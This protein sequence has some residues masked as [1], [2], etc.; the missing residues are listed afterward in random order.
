MRL[1]APKA[2]D[3]RAG[4][5]DRPRP[6]ALRSFR[7]GD[8]RRRWGAGSRERGKLSLPGASRTATVEIEPTTFSL[9]VGPTP[10]HPLSTSVFVHAA[11][12]TAREVPHR[13][14]GF[15]P[16]VMPRM[17]NTPT[18]SHWGS[19]VGAYLLSG[20]RAS[21]LCEHL[22][23]CEWSL[24]AAGDMSGPESR[25]HRLALSTGHVLRRELRPEGRRR[26]E[27]GRTSW[28]TEPPAS[29]VLNRMKCGPC[30][31]LA[32]VWP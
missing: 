21:T 30:L 10:S 16:R 13:Y 31:A 18:R 32:A 4:T 17:P 1:P 27:R 14:P 2:R 28:A 3:A 15:V 6:R 24:A 19:P 7:T 11:A 20:R 5:D 23:A 8:W 26:T 22:L 9:R 29:A 12:P 25:R